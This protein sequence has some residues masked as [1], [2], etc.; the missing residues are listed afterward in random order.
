[1]IERDEARRKMMSKIRK[2]DTKPELIVRSFLFNQGL[3]F[4]KNVKSL[5]GCPDVVLPRYRTIIMVNGCFWHA[6]EGCKLNRLP[7]SRQDY[8]LPKINGNV[9]R[10]EENRKKLSDLGWNVIT[11]WECE[12]KKEVCYDNLT[13]LIKKIKG[14]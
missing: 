6:H 2:I 4:R 13:K 1:M 8:W 3:R 7:K 11:I 10:D 9:A 14:T 5:P 12:L